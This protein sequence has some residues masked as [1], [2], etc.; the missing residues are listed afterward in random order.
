[1]QPNRGWIWFFVALVLLSAAAIT[2]NWLYNARQQLTSDELRAAQDRWDRDGPRDYDLVINK[3]IGSPAGGDGKNQDRITVEVRGGKAH[4]GT[5]NGQPLDERLLSQYDMAGWLSFVEEFLRQAD[6]PDAPRTFLVA[7]FD[8]QT[9][10]LRRFRRSVRTT[11]EWVDVQF[12][13]K[14]VNQPAGR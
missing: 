8:P 3:T 2:I 5:I 11:R 13:L 6:K 14:P 12:Q 1:M 7:D 10:A 9:G 4:A